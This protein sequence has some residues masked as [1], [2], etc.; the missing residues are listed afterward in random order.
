MGY[1]KDSFS[2]AEFEAA[3]KE[4]WHALW[5]RNENI[6]DSKVLAGVLSTMFNAQQTKD[7]LTAASSPKYKQRLNDSTQTA[8]ERGAF[9]APWFWV[10]NAEGKEEPFFGSDR[11]VQSVALRWPS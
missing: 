7:I 1:I 6:S 4:M 2:R 5:T 8:L 9:G 10:R 11:L 3:F